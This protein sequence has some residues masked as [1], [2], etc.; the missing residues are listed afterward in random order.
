MKILLVTRPSDIID[1][2]NDGLFAKPSPSATV[3]LLQQAAAK[4]QDMPSVAIALG[5]T[6]Y[7]VSAVE[8]D[9]RLVRA[10]KI[11]ANVPELLSDKFEKV[12][13]LSSLEENF[14]IV[15]PALLDA[16]D[17]FIEAVF[18]HMNAKTD[19]PVF[20]IIPD[21]YLYLMEQYKNG[22]WYNAFCAV[23]GISL[24]PNICRNDWLSAMLVCFVKIPHNDI[25]SLDIDEMLI[26]TGDSERQFKFVPFTYP[27]I[28]DPAVC[29][30][31]YL[32]LLAGNVHRQPISHLE[33]GMQTIEFHKLCCT[34]NGIRGDFNYYLGCQAIKDDTIKSLVDLLDE[35]RINS[36]KV[37]IMYAPFRQK[38]AG[39]NS[40]RHFYTFWDC[41]D[42]SSS[43][44]MVI[45][46]PIEGKK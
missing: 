6:K 41:Y 8:K 28:V 46:D 20:H 7:N 9:N 40:M 4:V 16:S 33:D 5:Y 1:L 26:N 35:M 32:R 22:C 17:I 25:L 27:T 44:K 38:S 42:G 2:T 24:H 45:F 12:A 21:K 31:D 3:L 15:D 14:G 19:V 34:V 36:A 23:L 10:P 29:V 39:N 11:V 30:R 18:D 37:A 43:K 13:F